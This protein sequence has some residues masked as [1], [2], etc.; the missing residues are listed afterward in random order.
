MRTTVKQQRAAD[1][2]PEQPRRGG[3]LRAEGTAG[4]ELAAEF[5]AEPGFRA[6]GAQSANPRVQ[7]S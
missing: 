1:G 5:S 6:A 7:K 4:A 2:G 3:G